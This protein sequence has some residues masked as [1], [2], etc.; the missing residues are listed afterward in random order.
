MAHRASLAAL[1][2]AHADPSISPSAASSRSDVS[3]RSQPKGLIKPGLKSSADNEGIAQRKYSTG[4]GRRRRSSVFDVENSPPAAVGASPGSAASGASRRS[5]TQVAIGRIKVRVLAARNLKNA[6]IVGK[7]DPFIKVKVGTSAAQKTSVVYGS[8]APV[9]KDARFEFLMYTTTAAGAAVEV[10]VFDKGT[11]VDELIGYHSLACERTNCKGMWLAVATGKGECTGEVKVDV[12][13]ESFGGT[14]DDAFAAASTASTA[15][16]TAAGAERSLDAS[17]AAGSGLLSPGQ[18]YRRTSQAPRRESTAVATAAATAS[19]N[20]ST[21]AA[22]T[23]DQVL[24]ENEQSH[25]QREHS[26]SS[27]SPTEHSPLHGSSNSS[28]AHIAARGT[29]DSIHASTA[30]RRAAKPQPQNQQQPPQQ[31]QQQQRL[32]WLKRVCCAALLCAVPA[33]LHT[34][35]KRAFVQKQPAAAVR[36]FRVLSP[37]QANTCLRGGKLVTDAVLCST[38]FNS[39]S[40]NSSS[41]SS[42]SSRKSSLQDTTVWT[43][44]PLPW[45]DCALRTTKRTFLGRYKQQCLQS[46]ARR[47]RP[48]PPAS[49]TNSS[50][51]SSSSSSST[52]PVPQSTAPLSLGPCSSERAGGWS[53]RTVGSGKQQ[54]QQLVRS[55]SLGERCLRQRGKGRGAVML[56]A[57][58]SISAEHVLTVTGPQGAAVTPFGAAK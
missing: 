35:T 38:D 53:V 5:S 8:R 20:R 34:V 13:F 57:C 28:G 29:L 4:A 46:T 51:S 3:S 14:L 23:L 11:V 26:S 19:V 47:Q 25:V 24:A 56:D 42:S 54:Q 45:G 21:A 48:V 52:A 16:N 50:N 49:S 18:R 12:E 43:V 41:S 9:W 37:Q 55:D 44:H 6:E 32:L 36:S 27:T 17:T 7:S 22:R 1:N 39:T 58:D 15:N 10:M 33:V 30:S 40:S 2:A 31:Q